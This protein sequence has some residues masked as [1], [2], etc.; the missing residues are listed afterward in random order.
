MNI[1]QELITSIGMNPVGATIGGIGSVIAVVW[2]V[3]G[4]GFKTSLVIIVGGFCLCGYLYTPLSIHW[5][6]PPKTIYLLMFLI[7]F[8]S[9]HVY[10]FLD[11]SA[12]QLLMIAF[13]AVTSWFKKK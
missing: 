10:R 1:L 8:I 11:A 7:G 13:N 6:L 9:N 5:P 12:P 3:N 4:Y 2:K